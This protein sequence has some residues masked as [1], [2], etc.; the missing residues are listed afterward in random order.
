MISRV[1]R[2]LAHLDRVSG[3]MEPRFVRFDST[4]PGMKSV[5]VMAYSDVPEPEYLT[6][7]TYG[8]SLAEHPEWTRSTAE[9]VLSVKTT[10]ADGWIS[11]LGHVAERFRGD[12]PFTYG[13]TVNCG[14]PIAPDTMMTAFVAF[15][16]LVLERKDYECIDVSPPGHEGHDLISVI[17]LVPI[18]GGER[19]FIHERGLEAF[20]RLGFDAYDVTRLSAV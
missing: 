20:A 2:F 5:T 15:P 19:T 16:A 1:E 12:C 3:G 4:K 14:E 10:H 11:A 6:A 13:D 8:V 17:G 9:L 7:I 18:H